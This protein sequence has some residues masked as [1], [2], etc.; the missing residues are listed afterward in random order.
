MEIESGWRALTADDLPAVAALARR[1]LAADGGMPLAADPSFLA[2]RFAADGGLGRVAVDP[3]GTLVAAGAV[4][5]QKTNGVRRAVATGLVDPAHRGRGL[6][7]A[8]LDWLLDPALVGADRV[9]LETEALTDPARDLFTARGLRQT[10]AEDVL[11]FDL[12]GAEPPRIDLP[13][14]L[15]VRSWSPELVE[16]FFAVY[17]DAFAQRPGFPGWSVGQWVEWTT[18]DEDFRPDWSLLATDPA[19]ADLGFVTA[20]QG[21][22]VQVGVRPPARGR[23]LGAALVV[24]ALRRMRADGSAEALLDVNVDNPAVHLYRRLGFTDLGRRARFEPAG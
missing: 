21:W 17:H 11:R 12:A 8:L 18:D 4:R 16:R 2:R 23:R 7:T 10:F 15:T 19:G 9:T 5:P 13:A 1:C 3:A 6:G 20:G 22:I 14:G 24:E